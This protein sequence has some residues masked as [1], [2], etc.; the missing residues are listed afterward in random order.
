MPRIG[1]NFFDK[2]VNMGGNTDV[3]TTLYVVWIAASVAALAWAY[4]DTVKQKF[5]GTK[6]R[7]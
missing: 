6:K 5:C 3:L 2:E 4:R 7:A 1:E